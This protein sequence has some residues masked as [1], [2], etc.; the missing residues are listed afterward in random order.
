MGNRALLLNQFGDRVRGIRLAKNL[1]QEQLA[2]KCKLDR[3]YISSLERGKRNVSLK[4]LA[5]LAEAL[6]ISLSELL[7]GV[8]ND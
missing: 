3:T 1:S 4:N 8:L 7:D 2:Q 6:E 5:A